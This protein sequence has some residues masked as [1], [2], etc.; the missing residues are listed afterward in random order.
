MVQSYIDKYFFF[1]FTFSLIFVILLY[2]VIGFQFTDELC[3]LALFTLFFYAVFKTPNWQFNKTFLITLGVFLFYTIY[4]I[5][6][7]SN[8][9]RAIINDL[10]IQLKPYIAFFCVYQLKPF[11]S[12]GRKLLLKDIILLF[13]MLFLLPLGIAGGFSESIFDRIIGHAAYYGIAVTIT[14]LAY[15]YCSKF[16]V[17]DK[18]TFILMLSIG[19]F[20]GRSK[21]YG[22]FVFAL[23]MMLFFSKTSQFKFSLRTILILTFT[24]GA[25]FA[26]AWDKI[27]LY[28]FQAIAG[29]PDVD[30]DMIARF[31]FYRTMPEI[32]ID[33]FPFG[34]GFATY[35]TH[36]SGLFYSDIYAE[37][38]INYVYGLTRNN[39]KFIS[40]T[41]YP[42]L[43]Q[44]G[45]AGILLC[46]CFWGYIL[47]KAF[48]FYLQNTK[49]N[50]KSLILVLFIIA[51]LAIEGTT[52]STFIA[53]GGFVVM[54]LMGL[55]LSGMRDH[56]VS[57]KEEAAI[58]VLTENT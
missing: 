10:I 43:A 54:M 55:V 32:L 11:I 57:K 2:N 21:F 56:D 14:S 38:D 40:D 36:S 15:L 27:S 3:V 37:Y 17:R 7:G 12:D 53:Q 42:S 47:R 33:Y 35:A 1:L 23:F 51:F 22:F 18:W 30:E 45:V 58:D 6:I 34:S 24:F 49:K 28:F 39:P 9:K 25:M 19:L 8:A 31:V 50:L 16:S 26:V 48:G 4:S 52:G 46:L 20:C 44:F 41:F 5:A 13:W 29:N